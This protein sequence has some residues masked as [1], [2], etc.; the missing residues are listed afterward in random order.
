MT[1][2]RSATT[3]DIPEN[4][5]THRDRIDRIFGP[6]LIQSHILKH[7]SN[8]F[9]LKEVQACVSLYALGFLKQE[10]LKKHL[11][12]HSGELP[13]NLEEYPIPVLISGTQHVFEKIDTDVSELKQNPPKTIEEFLQLYPCLGYVPLRVFKTVRCGL[14][15][16]RQ[17]RIL[18][19]T[20]DRNEEAAR[21][22]YYRFAA[23]YK[24]NPLYG[25][26][27]AGF[28]VEDVQKIFD[29]LGDMYVSDSQMLPAAAEN[30]HL[31]IVKYL[32]ETGAASVWS[33][34]DKGFDAFMLAC[35][36][37]YFDMV[38]YLYETGKF[39]PMPQRQMV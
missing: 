30:G 1:E 16:M 20:W 27:K 34:D 14:S 4:K 22:R 36:Y 2:T 19:Q 25:A 17:V 15:T 12:R 31:P 38:K 8:V 11:T 37:G 10:E 26:C 13:L 29:L 18:S 32:H 7:L 6:G 35:L 9:C 3:K 23:K 24:V 33:T 5:S 39:D 28:D 21:Q